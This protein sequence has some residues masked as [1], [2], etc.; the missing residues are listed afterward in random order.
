MAK[1]KGTWLEVAEK[2]FNLFDPEVQENLQVDLLDARSLRCDD[3]V[4]DDVPSTITSSYEEIRLQLRQFVDE[5][6]GDACNGFGSFMCATT[7]FSSF[8]YL[9]YQDSPRPVIGILINENSIANWSIAEEHLGHILQPEGLCHAWLPSTMRL[10]VSTENSPTEQPY[11][12]SPEDVSC[13]YDIWH[14]DIKAMGVDRGMAVVSDNCLIYPPR[15][16]PGSSIGTLGSR[17][18]T[19]TATCFLTLDQDPDKVI[20]LTNW[21]VVLPDQ[22]DENVTSAVPTIATAQI[23]IQSPSRID[24]FASLLSKAIKLEEALPG[25]N[26]GVNRFGET[27]DRSMKFMSMVR[28]MALSNLM[29]FLANRQDFTRGTVIA[30]SGRKTECSNSSGSCTDKSC[31]HAWLDWALWHDSPPYGEPN[32]LPF[33]ETVRMVEKSGNFVYEPPSPNIIRGIGR[34]SSSLN[35]FKMGRTTGLT[36]GM[37]SHTRMD[38]RRAIPKLGSGAKIDLVPPPSESEATA[39]RASNDAQ[40]FWSREHFISIP[41]GRY[42]FSE[43]G[44]SGAPVLDEQANLVGII[45]AKMKIQSRFVTLATSMDAVKKDIEKSLGGNV[46]LAGR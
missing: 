8:L 16:V 15:C 10:S 46:R 11:L 27:F 2:I 13:A 43:E 42:E 33:P 14:E 29:E 38:L 12:W 6:L 26:R 21:H 18:G 19:G 39:L 9:S 22:F 17:R 5:H 30:A 32:E 37:V 4:S 41:S 28:A 3:I 35:V 44:D 23:G 25:E 36:T 1:V 45:Y 24:L 31:N 34:L 20:G 40:I 7:E